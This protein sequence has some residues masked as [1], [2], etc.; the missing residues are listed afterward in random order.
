MK[1]RVRPSRPILILVA[2][3]LAG[4]GI[5]YAQLEGGERGVTPID[6]SSTYEVED[7]GRCGGQV[8]R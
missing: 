4:A 1:L 7:T 8:R 3:S 6:S 2:V 5:V